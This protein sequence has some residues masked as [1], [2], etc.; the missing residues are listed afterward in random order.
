MREAEVGGD[1]SP[2]VI[3]DTNNSSSQIATSTDY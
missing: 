1:Y 2:V 3:E